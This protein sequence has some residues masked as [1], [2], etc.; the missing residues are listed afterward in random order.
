VTQIRV[1]LKADANIV[2]FLP[3]PNGGMVTRTVQAR[4]EDKEPSTAPCP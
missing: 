2:G 1:T 4:L 3:V